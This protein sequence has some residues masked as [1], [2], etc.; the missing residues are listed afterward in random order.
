MQEIQ[1]PGNGV[2]VKGDMALK[3]CPAKPEKWNCGE[4][5]YWK[6]PKCPWLD[7][8]KKGLLKRSDAACGD[9][10]PIKRVRST[11]ENEFFNKDGVFQPVWFAEYLLREYHWRT[12]KDTKVV[13]VWNPVKGVYTPQG[14]VLIHREMTR[15]LGDN[16]RKR[17]MNDVV[18]KIQGETF[19]E[20]EIPTEF[21]SCKNGLLN[22]LSDHFGEYVPDFFIVCSI[23]V[24]YDATA[25]CPKIKHF[26]KDV[27]GEEQLPVIQELLGYCL[28]QNYRYPKAMM[29]VGEGQNGKST[30]LNL[31]VKFLGEDNVSHASLQSLCNNRFASADLHQ[32]LANIHADIPQQALKYTGMFKQLTGNDR[33]RSERKHQDSFRFRNHAKLFFSTNKVPETSDDTL[34]FFE[35]WIIISCNNTFLPGQNRDPHILDKITTPEELSGLLNWALKGLRRLREKGEFTESLASEERRKRY[36]HA[37]NTALAFIEERLET[38]NNPEDVICKNEL[39]KYYVT[40]CKKQNLPPK[41][42][43]ELTKE[44]K[45][46]LPKA[47]DIIAKDRNRKSY[48]AWRYLKKKLSTL[49]TPPILFGQK[50]EDSRTI[51]GSTVDNVDKPPQD[52][53]VGECV[54]CGNPVKNGE[55][56]WLGGKPC[57]VRCSPERGKHD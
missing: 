37:S 4:C 9:F 34:A 57:H 22:V 55:L 12:M 21:V 26:L 18:F 3:A 47:D 56:T 11:V 39:Y 45:R 25:D 53:V 32:K 52:K 46:Q 54:M 48:R 20:R 5:V 51:I 28:L 35:R 29:L 44:M 42:Q 19:H 31:F 2:S 23:P 36:I 14:E 30:L 1:A 40:W 8:A 7:D 38:T 43:A 16:L 24:E 13:W 41:R 50:Q 6:T 49:S 33:I 15:L 17:Y 10:F 27:V